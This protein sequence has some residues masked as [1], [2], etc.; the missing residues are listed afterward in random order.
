MNIWGRLGISI[1]IVAFF[2]IVMTEFLQSTAYYETWKWQICV[3]FIAASMVLLVVGRIL[4]ARWRRANA[5]AAA[6][7]KKQ[8]DGEEDATP[9][10][11]F[12]L[13]DLSYW[14]VMF[15]LFGIVII[16]IIPQ[17]KA[18]IAVPQSAPVKAAARQTPTNCPTPKPL[19][20]SPEQPRRFPRVILQGIIYRTNDSSVIIN[21]KTVFVGDR[22]GEAKVVTI[23]RTTATLEFEG[24]YRVLELIK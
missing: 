4:N 17:P 14:G 8:Q 7:S 16:F 12:L 10:A 18:V 21:G 22:I 15:L 24:Q 6:R 9:E 13:L 23:T 11:P 19:I 1:A 3:G 2:C 20:P 5:A